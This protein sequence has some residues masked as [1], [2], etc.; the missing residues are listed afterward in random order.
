[1]KVAAY[2]ASDRLP[3][4]VVPGLWWLGGCSNSGAW[5]GRSMASARH[6]PCSCWL[7]VGS[8]KTLMVDTGHIAHWGPVRDQL[9]VALGGRPLDFVFPTHQE[10]PHAGNLARL[11]ELH[12]SAVAV[13]DVRDYHLFFPEIDRSRLVRTVPG[14]ELELGDTR[15]VFLEPAWRDLTGTMWGYDTTRKA[16]F[17]SDGLGHLHLHES[18]VCGMLADELPAG[19]SVLQERF[20]ANAGAFHWLRWRDP[21]PSV[22]AYRALIERYPVEI[23]CSSHSAPIVSQTHEFTEAMLAAIAQ[24]RGGMPAGAGPR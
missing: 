14:D 7:L 13:G 10:L 16:I 22:R 20:F 23:I 15:F 4:E 12:A 24:G 5:P 1:M 6:E 9:A 19:E 3:R 17:S 11:L 18:G 2:T 21:A 8:E